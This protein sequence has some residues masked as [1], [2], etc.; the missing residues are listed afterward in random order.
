M[1]AISLRRLPWD[2]LDQWL[3]NYLADEER[4]NT[5]RVRAAQETVRQ[6]A[7]GV[8]E[9]ARQRGALPRNL[10][11]LSPTRRGSRALLDP[12]GQ[13][14]QYV[15]PGLFN[16]GSFDVYSLRGNSRAPAEWIG[17]W[18]MPFRFPTAI[19]GESLRVTGGGQGW[20]RVQEIT[21]HAVPPLSDGKHLFLRLSGPGDH[22][23]LPLPDAAT[24]GVYTVILSTVTSWDYGIVQWSLDGQL[25]GSPMDG[26]SPDTWRRV[27][28]ASQVRLANRPHELR[29][30]VVGKHPHSTGYCA[31]LDAILLR[32][33]GG[34]GPA[35]W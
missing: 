26:Y 31:S 7:K 24:P 27:S 1:D 32:R 28:V 11:Q 13:P 22:G 20:A 19:E 33:G 30:E 8:S 23:T 21:N 10:D 15:S 16:P 34:T 35:K 25:L 14:Y 6:L 5:E 29:V 12:W 9:F 2:H 3:A 17:N 4:L 18:E